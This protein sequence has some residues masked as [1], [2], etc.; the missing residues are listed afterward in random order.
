MNRLT[1]LVDELPKWPT[2]NK[3]YT[4]QKKEVKA[5]WEPQNTFQNRLR[6]HRSEKKENRI[7]VLTSPDRRGPRGVGDKLNEAR[8]ERGTKRKKE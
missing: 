8:R 7:D 4:T 2:E 1:I 6:Y 5:R 3:L